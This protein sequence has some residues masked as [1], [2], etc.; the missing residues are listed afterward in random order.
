MI[1]KIILADKMLE[2]A[3]NPWDPIDVLTVNDQVV[4]L[5]LCQGEYHWHQHVNEDELFYVLKGELII[6]MKEEVNLTLQ[7]GELAV[8]PKAVEHC[9]KSEEDTY[10]LMF[11]PFTLQSQGD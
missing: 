11:E 10:I 6:Q 1:S 5:A 3:G 4:R 2:V 7:E 9:P 8:I